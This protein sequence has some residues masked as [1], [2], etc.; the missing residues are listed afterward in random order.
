MNM[1]LTCIS[2]YGTLFVYRLTGQIF[3]QCLMSFI[4]QFLYTGNGICGFAQMSGFGP[5]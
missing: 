1:T 4:R 2:L 5:T 3:F